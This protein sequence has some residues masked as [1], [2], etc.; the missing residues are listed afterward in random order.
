MKQ[1]Y[2]IGEVAK[3]NNLTIK[4]LRYYHEVGIIEPAYIDP[5]SGYRYYTADQFLHMDI[6]KYCRSIGVSIKELQQL[7]EVKDTAVLLDFL[8]RKK[9]EIENNIKEMA[10]VIEDIDAID[11]VVKQSKQFL[12]QGEIMIQTLP[13]RKLVVLPCHEIEEENEMIVYS[14][15]KKIVAEQQLVVRDYGRG[16]RMQGDEVHS[17]YAF[18]VLQEVSEDI[19]VPLKVLPQGK[20]LTLSYTKENQEKQI[21]KL[22]AYIEAHDLDVITF[23]ELDL[24]VDFFNT[25]TY[26]CQLQMPL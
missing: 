12:E 15:L 16:Y 11:Q 1:L 9:A 24:M 25:Q 6:V 22:K 19:K 13:E 17:E 26:S 5:D 10:R 20:Y 23:M 4:A 14:K 18:A 2:G 21:A 3:L 7:F 8:K